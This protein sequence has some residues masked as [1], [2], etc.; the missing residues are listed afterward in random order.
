M[1]INDLI[2]TFDI[3][4]SNEEKTLMERLSTP[5]KI[6][7]LNEREQQVVQGMIRK[8]LVKKIGWNDPSVVINDKASQ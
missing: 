7:Q 1:K 4:S 2:S 8:S 3:W 6:S 5:V